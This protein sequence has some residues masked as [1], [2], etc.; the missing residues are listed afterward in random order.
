MHSIQ[1][2]EAVSSSTQTSSEISK[3][4]SFTELLLFAYK[5]E[6]YPTTAKKWKKKRYNW[7]FRKKRKGKW[8]EWEKRA[9]ISHQEPDSKLAQEALVMLVIIFI[10]K[11]CVV[12]GVMGRGEAHLS[13]A[14]EFMLPLLSMK[15][16]FLQQA[17]K[18]AC[19][20]WMQLSCT[21]YRYLIK[22][23]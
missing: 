4:D 3:S 8:K 18:Q 9:R 17:I 15:L 20:Q 21:G 11:V 12:Q 2:S 10:I 23:N 6:K 16:C 1:E 5:S 13:P 14:V 19:G 22:N 7:G